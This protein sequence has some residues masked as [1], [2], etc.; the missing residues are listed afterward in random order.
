MGN[1]EILSG[2]V[3]SEIVIRVEVFV[4]GLDQTELSGHYLKLRE[5]RKT[6]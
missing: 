2:Q 4:G 3:C 6:A 1:D 5:V